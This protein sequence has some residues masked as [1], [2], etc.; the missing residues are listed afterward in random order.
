MQAAFLA[1]GADFVAAAGQNFMRVGLMAD[2]PDQ[3]IERRVI[4]VVQ[5]HGQFHRAEA[6]GKVTAGTA[7]AVQ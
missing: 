2:V 1:N 5:R 4:H 3:A 7:D 6:R